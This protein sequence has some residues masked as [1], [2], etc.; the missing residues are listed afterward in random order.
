M[1]G[2]EP[3]GPGEPRAARQTAAALADGEQ[4]EVARPAPNGARGDYQ[5]QAPVAVVRCRAARKRSYLLL[6]DDGEH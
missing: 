5:E 4:R 2:D 6:Q 3:Q 1:A